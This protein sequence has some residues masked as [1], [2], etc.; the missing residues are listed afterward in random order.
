K[1]RLDGFR[2]R[3]CLIKADAG[4]QTRHA[5]EKIGPAPRGRLQLEGSPKPHF[6]VR[7]IQAG[8]HYTYDIE[9]L[10]IKVDC[11]P[12]HVRIGSKMGPPEGI[13]EQRDTLDAGAFFIGKECAPQ[14]SLHAQHREKVGRHADTAHPFGRFAARIVKS[15]VLERAHA[16]ERVTLCAP[17]KQVSDR[18]WRA[19]SSRR[20]WP[21]VP[22]HYQAPRIFER[23]RFEEHSIDNTED[24]RVRTDAQRQREHGN[25]SEDWIFQQHSRAIP[26]ILP[27]SIHWSSPF[28]FPIHYEN[29]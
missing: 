18:Q 29:R 24:R 7:E 10:S 17:V 19:I 14:R 5:T 8:R 13:A 22:H 21:A 6:F 26:Q 16:L 20:L 23:Q 27:E 25:Q 12:N 28:G 11:A 15:L 9:T 3:T 4:T 2:L 1:T